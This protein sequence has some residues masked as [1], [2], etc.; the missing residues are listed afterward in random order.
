M[1]SPATP[2][3]TEETSVSPC[4]SAIFGLHEPNTHYYYAGK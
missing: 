4:M 3:R 1:E 2:E